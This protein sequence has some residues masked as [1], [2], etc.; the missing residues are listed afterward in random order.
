MMN[1]PILN[2]L[3]IVSL[4]FLVFLFRA[5]SKFRTK[6]NQG[7]STTR[8]L[9]MGSEEEMFYIPGDKKKN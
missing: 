7:N 6:C 8:F 4:L 5:I 2:W 3:L 1:D 9:E